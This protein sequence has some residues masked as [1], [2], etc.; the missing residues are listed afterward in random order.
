MIR[1]LKVLSLALVAVCAMSAMIASA[2]SAASFTSASYPST[3]TGEG[4]IASAEL[5]KLGATDHNAKVECKHSTYHGTLSAPSS[6]LTVQPH[7]SECTAFGL[8][9]TVDA[10]SCQYVFHA[11]STSSSTVDVECGSK[12]IL[13][14]A[15]TCEVAVDTQTG[16]KS[17]GTKNNAGHVDVTP[18]VTG[19]TYT[20]LR[21]GFL[22]PLTGTGHRTGATYTSASP[23]TVKGSNGAISV[24]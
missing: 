19:I 20:S 13:I 23:I 9:A 4:G 12:S 8:S 18:N 5:F 24:S 15:G 14:V 16:L 22:C 10:T 17:A 6:T 2:A 21:D 1:N 7:Y 11:T 3:I